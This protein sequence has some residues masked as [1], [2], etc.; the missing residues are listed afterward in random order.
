MVLVP[1]I[2]D[3]RPVRRLD[4]LALV[5]DEVSRPFLRVP[6]K[7]RHVSTMSPRFSTIIADESED[8]IYLHPSVAAQ[9]D[10]PLVRRVLLDDP[11]THW[12]ESHRPDGFGD[13][14]GPVPSGAVIDAPDHHGG[15][16]VAASEVEAQAVVKEDHA[17]APS[18]VHGDRPQVQAVAS[19]IV[20]L[21][22]EFDFGPGSPAVEGPAD[23]DVLGPVV[24]AMPLPPLHRSDYCPFV[25][26]SYDW[27][28]V[29]VDAVLPRSKENHLVHDLWRCDCANPL[30]VRLMQVGA[31]I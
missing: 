29:A 10:A 2:N 4:D 19:P 9:N 7:R 8:A 25:S 18:V 30:L 6:R 23:G 26:L 14:P 20:I 27:N 22:N 1:C 5:R 16:R 24:T 21:H 13:V 11:L 31:V 15:R 28:S 3:D 17:A 12:Q